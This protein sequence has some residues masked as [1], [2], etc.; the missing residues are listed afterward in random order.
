MYSNVNKT[1]FGGKTETIGYNNGRVFGSLEQH[2]NSSGAIGQ[3]NVGAGFNLTTPNGT[4]I[5]GS[6]FHQMGA[7]GQASVTAQANLINTP[8]HNANVW[9]QH[10]RSFDKN[11]KIVGP[12]T[13]SAGI[14]YNHASGL[15]AFGAVSQTH[16][17]PPVNTAGVGMPISN[18]GLNLTGSSSFSKGMKPNHNVGINFQRN[19]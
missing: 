17:F 8:N 16:G 10:N 2:R 15:N 13:N 3:Q 19:F 14:N 7:G 4:G 6:G 9:A 5:A 12:E 1:P 11:L 18:T